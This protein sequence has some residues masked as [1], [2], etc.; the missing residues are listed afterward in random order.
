MKRNVYIILSIA[1]L[2]GAASDSFAQL[3]WSHHGP[4]ALGNRTRAIVFGENETIY[5][6]SSG[7]GVY[8]ST[9]KGQSWSKVLGYTGNPTVTALAGNGSKLYAGTG[10]IE[11]LEYVGEAD[12]RWKPTFAGGT[13]GF[14]GLPGSG[15]YVSTDNGQTWS[16]DNATT[17]DFQTLSYEGPFLGV[18]KITVGEGGRVFVATSEGAFYS[19]DDFQSMTQCEGPDDFKNEAVYDIEVSGSTVFAGSGTELYI[20]SDNG[21]TFTKGVVEPGSQSF[22]QIRVEIAISPDNP[23]IVY[24][25][26]SNSGDAVQFRGVFRSDDRGQTWRSYSPSGST[27]F[28]PLG[29][30]SRDAFTMAVKPG[31][32]DA[33]IVTGNNWFT[34]TD[35]LGWNKD[36]VQHFDPNDFFN[37]GKYLPRPIYTVAF[38]PNNPDEAFIGTGSTIMRSEDKVRTFQPTTAGYG[39]S[40]LVRVAAWGVEGEG[41]ERAVVA[42]SDRHGVIHNQ[43]YWKSQIT[44]DTNPD[45]IDSTWS[46]ATNRFGTLSGPGGLGNTENYSQLGLSYLYPGSMV[47]EGSDQGLVKSDGTYGRTFSQF[48]GLPFNTELVERPSSGLIDSLT[49]KK[50]LGIQ[51]DDIFINRTNPTAE[52]ANLIDSEP[53][54]P[55]HAFALDEYIPDNYI[56]PANAT[57]SELLAYPD[58]DSIQKLPHYLYYTS[59][60]YVWL[61]NFAFGS[62]EGLNPR[63]DRISNNMLSR[64]IPEYYTCITPASDGS[65]SIYIG[66][67]AGKIFRIDNAPEFEFYNAEVNL[68]NVVEVSAGAPA[69]YQQFMDGRWITDIAINPDVEGQIIVSFAGYGGEDPIAYTWFIDQANTFTP[70]FN[71]IDAGPGGYEQVYSVEFVKDPATDETVILAGTESG[72]YSTR[73]LSAFPTWTSELPSSY[74]K[75]PVY[76]IFVRKYKTIIVDDR[77][78]DF[79]LK[80]DNT[81]FIA[82]HGNGVWSTNEL[83]YNDGRTGNESGEEP[84][85]ITDPVVSIFPNPSEKGTAAQIGITLPANAQVQATVYTLDGRQV[86][87][88][89]RTAFEAGSHRMDLPS[90]DLQT[91]MYLVEV[92]I[93]D[94]TQTVN[95][96]L[97]WVVR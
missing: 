15:V 74:G 51:G 52:P 62:N 79:R 19:D 29:P 4:E 88:V 25:A 91:G 80:R 96:T 13:P 89:A 63:W 30:N 31:D 40:N 11:F 46:P 22:A 6:A 35:A 55:M 68:Q 23:D 75:Q 93:T 21:A 47:V 77:T 66:T 37:P 26:K 78:G 67:S 57:D 44:P 86:N 90:E 73:E 7:G 64:A 50:F 70:T 41:G 43:N 14:I 32:P 42:S 34:Y 69:I 36:D 58:R 1:L 87:Q 12:T 10:E 92:R 59:K 95:H 5:A 49:Y 84:L 27:G 17:R 48:Y 18:Q 8:Q 65:N 16:N 97:K 9:N 71:T 28:N 82:S 56:A 81:V 54:Y 2:L 72:L 53:Q 33:L 20:S 61:V 60:K 45:D 85:T 39:S 3:T 38:N 24:V 83:R 94:G 76:D